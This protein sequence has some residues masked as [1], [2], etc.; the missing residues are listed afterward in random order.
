MTDPQEPIVVLT[1]LGSPDT[2]RALVQQLVDS[3]LVACG[4]VVPGVTSTYRWQGGVTT[5]EE[6]LVLLK[7]VRGR[8]DA[9]VRA[10]EADHPYDVPELLAL[11]VSGGLPSYLAWLTAQTAEVAA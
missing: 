4:T 8:W 9:L 10:V 11:P 1:T 6:T 2:A 7:T 3:R 5:D